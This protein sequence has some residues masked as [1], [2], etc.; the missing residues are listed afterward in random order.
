MNEDSLPK[1]NVGLTVWKGGRVVDDID[2]G[3]YIKGGRP[4]WH[5]ETHN[6]VTLTGLNLIRDWFYGAGEYRTLK[7]VGIGRNP[8]MSQISDTWLKDPIGY[9]PFGR[10]MEDKGRMRVGIYVRENEYNGYQIAEAG[11]LT[12][13]TA[14]QDVM[15]ARIS[16][17]VMN[18]EWQYIM[19]YVWD[20]RFTI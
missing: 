20:C 4:V 12:G 11:L 14:S 16:H 15:Y 5:Y 17:P 13:Q 9:Y 8:A 3:Q 18:K 6:L 19:S 7:R 1:V 2:K 10:V